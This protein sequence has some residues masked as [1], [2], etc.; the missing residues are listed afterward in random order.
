MS[1]KRNETEKQE[2]SIVEKASELLEKEG[3]DLS[4]ENIKNLMQFAPN[5]KDMFLKVADLSDSSSQNVFDVLKQ[6]ISVYQD[7]LQRKDITQEQREAIYDRMDKH[8]MNAREQD[9]SNKKFI[10][11][12]IA[13][14]LTVLVTGAVKYGPK[15]IS[16][17]KK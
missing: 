9:D 3:I 12:V 17:V 16:K 14:A 6:I 15:I 4:L 1:E 5:I 10:G 8:A 7:E 11:G 13:G 2:S